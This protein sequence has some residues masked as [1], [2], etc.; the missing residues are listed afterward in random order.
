MFFFLKFII[1]QTVLTVNATEKGK[2]QPQ[3]LA[4]G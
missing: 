2:A 4:Q 1:T 3:T